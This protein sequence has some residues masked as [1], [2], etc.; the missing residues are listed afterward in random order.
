[1]RPTLLISSLLLAAGWPVMMG[2][3]GQE[4]SGVITLGQR[5]DRLLVVERKSTRDMWMAELSR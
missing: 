4:M 2:Q 1:M 5:D 3:P